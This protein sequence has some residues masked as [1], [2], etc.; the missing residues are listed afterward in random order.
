MRDRP[1]SKV[2]GYAEELHSLAVEDKPYQYRVGISAG[3][4]TNKKFF[5]EY[6]ES[7]FHGCPVGSVQVGT[8][9]IK[10]KRIVPRNRSG[11]T[12][13][14]VEGELI[15]SIDVA[16][17][18]RRIPFYS[19][20]HKGEP[21]EDYNIEISTLPVCIKRVPFPDTPKELSLIM[22]EDMHTDD[23]IEDSEILSDLSSLPG[24]LLDDKAYAACGQ[25][26]YDSYCLFFKNRKEAKWTKEDIKYW[27]NPDLDDIRKQ[28]ADDIDV[29]VDEISDE[30]VWDRVNH[31]RQWFWDDVGGN[32]E[33]Y[34][35]MYTDV[36]RHTPRSVD[37]G[38]ATIYP[39]T[40]KH[41]DKVLIWVDK[42]A[43][44]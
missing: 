21:K 13:N 4:A 34:L 6:G 36:D 11:C 40:G 7:K 17:G 10:T 28:L 2:I 27:D 14:T 30:Q 3:Y 38:A 9:C 32:M 41:D 16:K 8:A 26:G 43:E 44:F 37:I 20:L 22:G 25:E 23:H 39:A 42:G 29:P 24:Y 5:D 12:G 31:E 18:N 15:K 1:A 35:G 19:F 33:G